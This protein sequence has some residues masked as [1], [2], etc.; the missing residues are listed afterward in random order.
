VTV[1][2]GDDARRRQLDAEALAV[3]DE[4]VVAETVPANEL[5]FTEHAA[6]TIDE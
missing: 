6:H 4:I 3:D 5:V 2:D 1:A